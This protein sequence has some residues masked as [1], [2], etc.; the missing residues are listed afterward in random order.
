[1]GRIVSLTLDLND[2]P[3]D[4][5]SAIQRLVDE[6]HFFT[7]T[8]DQTPDLIPDSFQYSITV[9]SEDKIYTVHT[10]DTTMSNELRPLVD[11]L[12]KMARS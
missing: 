5:A 10:S 1:M 3:P 4:Q 9:E 8:V 6:A 12:V 7:R 2:I 11:E